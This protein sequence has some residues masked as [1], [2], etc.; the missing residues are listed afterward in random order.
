MKQAKRVAKDGYGGI[1][2]L[3]HIWDGQGRPQRGDT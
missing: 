1:E 3:Y 2:V